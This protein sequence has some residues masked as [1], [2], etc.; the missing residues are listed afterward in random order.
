MVQLAFSFRPD[1][2]SAGE[3]Y[4]FVAFAVSSA[5]KGADSA[6]YAYT[7]PSR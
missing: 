7:T 2:Y 1:Q 4:M 5:G 6:F 3:S